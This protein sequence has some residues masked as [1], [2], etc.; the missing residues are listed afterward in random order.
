MLVPKAKVD[1]I[2]KDE[3]F[4]IMMIPGFELLRLAI[5]RIVKKKHPFKADRNHI[6]HLI[7][8]KKGYIFT[9]I[10]IQLLFCSPYLL[11]LIINLIQIFL[12]LGRETDSLKLAT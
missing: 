11:N 6:H 10:I 4:L 2:N 7:I 8:D 5:H 1:Y 3:I 12:L 9:L